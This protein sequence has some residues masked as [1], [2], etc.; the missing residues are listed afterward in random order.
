MWAL[1]GDEE[2][3]GVEVVVW[4]AVVRGRAGEGACDERE[5]WGREVLGRFM[6]VLTQYRELRRGGARVFEGNLCE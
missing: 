4:P 5:S 1:D 6:L 3:G 2:V